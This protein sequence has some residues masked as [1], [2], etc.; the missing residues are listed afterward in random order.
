[1]GFILWRKLVRGNLYERDLFWEF[2]GKFA[3]RSNN[4]KLV[5]DKFNNPELYDLKKRH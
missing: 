2:N 4:F 5:I 1:M 3:I